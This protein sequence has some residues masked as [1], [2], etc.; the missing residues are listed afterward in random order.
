MFVGPAFI[1]V[2]YQRICIIALT[3]LCIK[4]TIMALIAIVAFFKCW[5]ILN[6]AENL[7]KKTDWLGQSL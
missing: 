2:Q 7:Q 6:R 3:Y 5:G 4:S 1:Q